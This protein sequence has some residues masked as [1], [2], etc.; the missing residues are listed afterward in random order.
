MKNEMV[1]IAKTIIIK[2]A[3]E[4]ELLQTI[5]KLVNENKI[6]ICQ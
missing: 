4:A 2:K 5:I 6:S 3:N 1:K